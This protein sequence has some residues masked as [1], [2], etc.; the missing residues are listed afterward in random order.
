MSSNIKGMDV[1]WAR[2]TSQQM[3]QHAGQVSGVCQALFSRVQA[4]SWVGRDKDA[5]CD[6][7]GSSFLP[8]ANLFAEGMTEQARA[9][10]E[11]ADRQDAASS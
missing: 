2:E 8:N 9:L 1:E 10:S 4:T 7:I 11:Q 5:I 6:D 3:D